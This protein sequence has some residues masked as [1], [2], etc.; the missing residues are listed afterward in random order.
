LQNNVYHISLF[1]F[2]H[3]CSH[4]LLVTVTLT[5]SHEWNKKKKA[6]K[7]SAKLSREV[8]SGDFLWVRR[9]E[10]VVEKISIKENNFSF[11]LAYLQFSHCFFSVL[12]FSWYHVVQHSFFLIISFLLF[13]FVFIFWLYSSNLYCN[14]IP[15]SHSLWPS[16]HP[17]WEHL[18]PSFL[19]V[20]TFVR[21]R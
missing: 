3:C 18:I 12:N 14:F 7:F 17:K 6:R 15:S 20:R 9:D 8:D 19:P 4:C 21:L 2:T 11:H 10:K 1:F 13:H 16:N 5:N